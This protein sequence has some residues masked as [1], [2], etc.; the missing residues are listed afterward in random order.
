MNTST[1]MFDNHTYY[2]AG[3]MRARPYYNAVAFANAAADLRRKYPLT[4]FISPS[5]MDQAEGINL[6]DAPTGT[7]VLPGLNLA[8][9]MLHDLEAI[10]FCDGV[11]VLPGWEFS[12]GAAVEVAFAKFLSIPVY[13]YKEFL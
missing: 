7:E 9:I 11:I 4:K 13:D 1:P 8:L 10:A 12:S 3:P 6:S 5:E 2:L